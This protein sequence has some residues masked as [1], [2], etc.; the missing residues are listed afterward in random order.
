MS[1]TT[2][3]KTVKAKG[4]KTTTVQV[5]KAPKKVQ[6]P[7]ESK[8]PVGDSSFFHACNDP[9]N[10]KK[11]FHLPD[12]F[13]GSTAI[14]KQITTIQVNTED[15]EEVVIIAGVNPTEGMWVKARNAPDVQSV[16][17]A[18]MR[19]L[20][21]FER[22]KAEAAPYLDK[23]REMTQELIRAE[24]A[25]PE[26]VGSLL[27]QLSSL[28]EKVVSHHG[29]MILRVDQEKLAN[30][31]THRRTAYP[32]YLDHHFE[33]VRM[34][35]NFD[36]SKPLAA[37]RFKVL[38]QLL[39]D[40]RGHPRERATRFRHSLS[41][42]NSYVMSLSRDLASAQGSTNAWWSQ[43][44]SQTT[45]FIGASVTVAPNPVPPVG[46][47]FVEAYDL[48]G[49]PYNLVTFTAPGR[50]GGRQ[51]AGV[52]MQNGNT[53]TC[54]FNLAVDRDLGTPQIVIFDDLGTA[55]T[56]GTPDKSGGCQ[57]TF[58]ASR[59]GYWS[60]EFHDGSVNVNLTN[61]ELSWTDSNPNIDWT[62]IPTPD[63]E[64]ISANTTGIR[65]TGEEFL[66]TYTGSTLE[67]AGQV[68]TAK[69]PSDFFQIYSPEDV[70]FASVAGLPT[71]YDGR[72]SD[73]ARSVLP[74]FGAQ[75]SIFMSDD[76]FPF[77]DTGLAAPRIVQVA[78]AHGQ[79]F[80][81]RQTML[82][83]GPST[84]QLFQNHARAGDPAALARTGAAFTSMPHDSANFIHLM[85]IS[86][87][88]TAWSIACKAW[89]YVESVAKWTLSFAGAMRTANEA[90]RAPMDQPDRK[91]R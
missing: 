44:G 62:Q 43:A 19:Q 18:D 66:L 83:E 81:V 2:T 56:G 76:S 63:S 51:V 26:K 21:I 29:D 78:K 67:D 4:G 73:G 23:I 13:V 38:T 59:T 33:R 60:W 72:L 65:K 89:P 80:R 87:A 90:A 25:D 86:A 74:P 75:Q 6:A 71:H 49:R 34:R 27:Q 82:L 41:V 57:I 28:R 10:A 8:K 64:T 77:D 30:F 91:R 53:Y 22:S 39:R 40:S 88:C 79:P 42:A 17:V 11:G 52:V 37:L 70:S 20:S 85:V 61:F 1:T 36:S 7:A 3:T 5:K 47:P 55:I 48:A 32:V 68:V 46:V 54:T 15:P 58:T 31:S 45:A 16:R 50:A 14:F 69:L 84:S 35:K 12:D 9:Y 24:K